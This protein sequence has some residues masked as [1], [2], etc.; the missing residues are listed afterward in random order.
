MRAALYVFVSQRSDKCT[1]R[2]IQHL[3]EKYRARTCHALRHTFGHDLV[4]SDPPV[5]LDV[6]AMLIGH[7]K[8]TEPPTLK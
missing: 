6:V 3:I 7:S 5:P 4:T 8:K 2:A 1:T